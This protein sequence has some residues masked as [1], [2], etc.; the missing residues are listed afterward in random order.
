[1]ASHP[2]IIYGTAGIAAFSPETR[3]EFEDILVKHNVKDLDTAYIYTNSEVT[4]KEAG[5]SKKFILH[6]KAPGFVPGSLAKQSV[7]D[8][9]KKSLGDLGEDS[10]ETYFLHSPDPTTP[11]EE[12]LSAIQEIYAAGKFKRFGLSNFKA[13]DVQKIYDIQKAAGSVL[14][15]VFQGNYN[16]VSRHIE[17][18]L[19]PVLRKLDISFFAYS[20]IAGGFLVKTA[21]SLREGNDTGRF[22]ANSPI[23]GLYNKLYCKD[24]LYEALDEWATIA[25]SL[26]IS[27][28]AL[29]YRWVTYN[30]A[31]KVEHGDAVIVGASK[32]AQLEESLKAI[33]DGPLDQATVDKIE[34]LWKKVEKDAPLDNYHSFAHGQN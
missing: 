27:K 1:M 4:L 22:A 5:W 9:A 29:A 21:A 11:I 12:T 28:A 26:K 10:V 25:D 7:L 19:F 2:K 23:G 30:S 15:S 18:D 6:T 20:P 8:G 16:A 14:P 13:A 32:P 33:E 24:S 31:L 3:Q 34:A 17:T